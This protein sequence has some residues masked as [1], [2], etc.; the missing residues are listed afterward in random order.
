MGRL[1]APEHDR[2]L[3]LGALVQETLDVALLRVVVVDS[4]LRSELDLL[5]VDLRLVLASELG[6]LLLLVAV[7]PVIHHPGDRRVG[8]RRYFDEVEPLVEGVLH[9]F[10]RGLDPEL[11]AVVV[12]QP[13]LRCAD[14][15][16]DPRL[17]NGPR[18]RFDR[19]PRPQRAI[20]KLTSI[21]SLNDKTAG[22]SGPGILDSRTR[23]NPAERQAREVRNV[24]APTCR[25]TA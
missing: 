18:R 13:H 1:A 24:G 25:L 23:L 12:D 19:A 5:D 3:D 17:R 22:S 21:L 14:V 6:L 2:H 16:V 4:D 8:L 20:T 11:V 10:F 15:I 9:R 7:L